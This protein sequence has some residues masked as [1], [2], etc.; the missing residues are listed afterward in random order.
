MQS[1]SGR[2]P[3]PM[4]G[5]MALSVEPGPVVA[6]QPLSTRAPRAGR[7]VVEA[8]H[9][10]VLFGAPA[11]LAA[12]PEIR[13]AFSARRAT[14]TAGFAQ[15]LATDLDQEGYLQVH[16]AAV[17]LDLERPAGVD[18]RGCACALGTPLAPLLDASQRRRLIETDYR[19]ALHALTAHRVD[20]KVVVT[21]TATSGPKLELQTSGPSTDPLVPAAVAGRTADPFLA[22]AIRAALGSDAENEDQLLAEDGLILRGVRFAWFRFLQG[23]LGPRGE[24]DSPAKRRLWA[25]LLDTSGLEAD[26][27]AVL[28]HVQEGL[29]PPPTERPV[30]EEMASTYQALGLWISERTGELLPEWFRRAEAIEH[31]GLRLPEAWDEVQCRSVSARIAGG[32]RAWMVEMAEAAPAS[33]A[34]VSTL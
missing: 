3:S 5:I 10:G 16:R 1:E 2:P 24:P 32:I 26:T 13:E 6:W 30:F 34:A 7:V 15:R 23:R 19:D 28:A 20:A 29:S 11:P 33:S 31:V 27:R 12:R 25:A 18:P 8:L 14:G 17:S 22:E 4:V 21:V 9:D